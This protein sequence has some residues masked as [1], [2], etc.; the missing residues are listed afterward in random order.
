[1]S[2]QEITT[3]NSNITVSHESIILHPSLKGT[4][5]PVVGKQ[6]RAPRDPPVSLEKK[7][8]FY[9]WVLTIMLIQAWR[10]LKARR[11]F[12][13][14]QR[15]DVAGHY[16]VC[17]LNPRILLSAPHDRVLIRTIPSSMTRDY[18]ELDDFSACPERE[19][20]N[21]GS[22]NYGGFSRSEHDSASLIETTLRLLPFN[23]PPIELA[24]RVNEELAKYMGSKACST[25]TSG[26]S[27]NLLA[28]TTAAQTAEKL[29]RHCVFLLDAE[30]HASM[31]TG[32]FINKRATTH[33]FKHNDITDLE[34]KLRILKAKE[35]DAHVCVAVEAILALRRVYNFCLLVDEAHGFMALGKG[36]RGSFEWWQDCGYDCPLQ[37]IDIMTGTMSK[38][39]C[40]IGGFVSAN[41]IYAAELERQ[42]TAQHQ[43]GA[44]TLST[45]SL[46]RVLSLINKPKF[47]QERMTALGR[48]A[49]FVADC[50]AQAG[51][52][53]LS[54]HGSPVV[55]FP[56]G[57]IQQAS[58]FHEEAM[59]R[60]FAV[61]CGVPPATPL[62]S[63]R[64]R[65]CI[66]ATTSWEDVLDLINMIIK[67]S[68]KL[69][70]KG[71][72]ATVFTPDTLP[73]QCPDDPSIA[74]QSIKSDASIRSY[75]ESLSKTYPGGDLEAKAPLNL[76]QS[77][78]A[79]EASVKAFSK[80]GLGPSSARWFYGTFDVFIALERRL[81]KL[82]PT[83]QRHSGRCRAMLGTDAHTMMLSLLSACANPYT[84]GVMNILLI[85]TTASLAVHDGAE[86]N[87]PRAETKIIYYEN[88]DNLVAKLRELPTDAS[89]LHLTLYLQTTSHDGSRILDLAATV[90]MIKSGMNAPDQLRGFKLI[91][92]D[93]GGLGKVG[94][95]HLGY[96]DLM[97]RDHGVSFL[98]QS[99]GKKLAPKT[100][101]IV[102]G[103]FFN[104][105]GQQGGYIISSASFIEV[106]TVSSKSFVFSTPP[107]P[108]QAA[109]SE[110]VLEILSRGTR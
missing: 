103:S 97:E 19:I 101:I 48:K 17:R 96:L 13:P 64:V 70:L 33:R 25:T 18:E 28:F 15:D 91:L 9:I 106:H 109:L 88:L 62:W 93:S 110:K 42:R 26:F 10:D 41:G 67:V 65:V 2:T 45:V 74:E 89:K 69:Q 14:L 102:T 78:E 90:K 34:Y 99:L 30:S 83:L 52:D 21:A 40:C 23:P 82:Y 27:A 55:C 80:Y 50:L 32:A 11:W 39:L 84:S 36:G 61:A 37:E 94:P 12:K 86:L 38:S 71:I 47:I 56:V 24:S 46:V 43:N 3:T 72:T 87:R 92:D 95:R 7:I 105:F 66:F 63:C 31:F 44:E 100:E 58:K 73:K 57:T 22:N 49:S 81:A 107:T 108:I 35:P 85:P 53:I 51:C 1:M 68:C 59:E 76:G 75:V 8:N 16:F 60:G 6:L 4:S 54:S 79:V 5:K 104:A 98:N 77:Q 20:V 29:G